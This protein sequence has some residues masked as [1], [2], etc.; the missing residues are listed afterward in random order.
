MCEHATFINKVLSLKDSTISPTKLTRVLWCPGS[1]FAHS[2]THKH[3]KIVLAP[4]MVQQTSMMC[5]AA[6]SESVSVCP[7]TSMSS[8]ELEKEKLEKQKG[9]S[10]E[11][12]NRFSQVV[13]SISHG[14]R[15]IPPF[16]RW[17]PLDRRCCH[18]FFDSA[19]CSLGDT[20]CPRAKL[21]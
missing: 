21:C 5:Y 1:V 19:N 17:T 11:T 2:N 15:L 4:S 16:I 10:K 3:L 8:E 6:L 14:V 13:F 9:Q 18:A 12:L 7:M 20:I